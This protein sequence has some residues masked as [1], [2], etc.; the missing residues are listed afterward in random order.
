MLAILQHMVPLLMPKL[1]SHY[2]HCGMS[3][4]CLADNG[5]WLISTSLFSSLFSPLHAW[6]TFSSWLYKHSVQSLAC[7]IS[8][9]T[10]IEAEYKLTCLQKV[11]VSRPQIQMLL[12]HILLSTLPMHHIAAT[13]QETQPDLGLSTGT[14][15]TCRQSWCRTYHCWI[16]VG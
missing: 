2:V 5:D 13:G 1:F 12:H 9:C 10:D 11:H 4:M 16:R 14:S 3:L 6:C 7:V 8:V 15:G